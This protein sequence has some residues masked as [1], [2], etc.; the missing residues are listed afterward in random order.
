[1]VAIS[2]MLPG[3]KM[4]PLS[5]GTRPAALATAAISIDA[6]VPSR[7][8]VCMYGLSWSREG[9]RLDGDHDD[10]LAG[11]DGAQCVRDANNRV[12]SCLDDHVEVNC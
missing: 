8:D 7:N 2:S 11:L 4:S 10:V 6:F 3:V 9:V 1:M 12:S 5:D